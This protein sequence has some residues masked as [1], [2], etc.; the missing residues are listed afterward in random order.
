[1]KYSWFHLW[2]AF[3][4]LSL[5]GQNLTPSG[6]F[7]S[8]HLNDRSETG[9]SVDFTAAWDVSRSRIGDFGHTEWLETTGHGPTRSVVFRDA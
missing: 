4:T 5:P 9:A 1:M 3:T 6:D 2:L 7:E 8:G